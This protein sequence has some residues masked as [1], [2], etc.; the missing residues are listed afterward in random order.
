MNEHR[1]LYVLT[2]SSVRCRVFQMWLVVP[3]D[4][5]YTCWSVSSTL[6]RKSLRRWRPL[7]THTALHWQNHGANHIRI[8]RHFLIRDS[9]NSASLSSLPQLT[10]FGLWKHRVDEQRREVWF[11]WDEQVLWSWLGLGIGAIEAVLSLTILTPADQEHEGRLQPAVH[12]TR[13]C[14]PQIYIVILMAA[15]LNMPCVT[16]QLCS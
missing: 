9:M 4:F 8:S 11:R 15:S 6:C 13:L 5:K 2:T 1:L 14:Y 10:L 3:A 7:H 16:P 12:Q